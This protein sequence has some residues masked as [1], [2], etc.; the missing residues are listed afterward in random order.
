M[1]LTEYQHVQIFPMPPVHVLHENI[2]VV[3]QVNVLAIVLL[4]V[5]VHAYCIQRASK[6][7]QVH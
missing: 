7:P 4:H 5:T 3:D 6:M 2:W 1:Q